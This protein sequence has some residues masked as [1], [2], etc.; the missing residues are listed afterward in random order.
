M[1]PETLKTPDGLLLHCR[2]VKP[3]SGTAIAT[4]VVVHGLGEHGGSLPYRNLDMHLTSHGIAV[5]TFDLRGHGQSGGRRMHANSWQDIRSDMRAFVDLVRSESQGSPIFLI[6]VSLGGLVV[7]NFAEHHKAGLAGVITVAPGVDTSGASRVLRLI[8][9]IL[10]RLI[11]TLALDPGLD[12]SRI[13]RDGS[14]V[15]RV[16]SDPYWQVKI[17]TRFGYQ[18]LR[19]VDETQRLAPQLTLPFLIL[20][21]TQDLIVPPASSAAFIERVGSSDKERRTYD[22][23]YHNLFIETNREQVFNLIVGWIEKHLE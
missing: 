5:Y 7:L 13:S 6:G 9:P 15:E 18:I 22:G 16:T 12:L 20:H 23:A 14:A 19:A 3:T 10:S 1:F 8:A 11:P 2:S 17:T 4:A 21:G